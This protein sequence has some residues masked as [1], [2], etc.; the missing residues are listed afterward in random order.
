MIK[1]LDWNH[2]RYMLMVDPV[3]KIMFDFLDNNCYQEIRVLIG[4]G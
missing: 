3:L 4:L 2:L 1:R